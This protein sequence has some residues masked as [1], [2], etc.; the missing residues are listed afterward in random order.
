MRSEHQVDVLIVGA[1]P[2]GGQLGRR[3]QALG[4]SVLLVDRLA[5]FEANA[6]S[7][8]GTVN[9]CMERFQLPDSVVG[10]K[11]RAL[12]IVTTRER[13]RWEEDEPVGTVLDFG[14]LRA[15]LAGEIEG[16][17]GAVW[18]GTEYLRREAIEGGE[19]VWLRRKGQE[20]A[21][22]AKVVV[23]ATGPARALMRGLAPAHAEYMRGTG[24]ELLVEV[25][26]EQYA[27]FKDTLVFYMGYKWM[28]RGYAWIFPMEA[29]TLKVGAGRISIG[30]ALT[31]PGSSLR[32]HVDL[33]LR[34][35][36]GIEEPKVLD[37]HGAVLKYALG[38]EDRFEDGAVIAIGDAVSTLNILGGEGIRHAMVGAEIALPFITAR[39]QDPARTFAGYREAVHA[40][41][42]A[43]WQASERH[44]RRKYLADSDERIDWQVRFLRTKR[45][46][47]ILDSLFNY[48]FRRVAL[49]SAPSYLAFKAK[50]AMRRMLGRA[51]SGA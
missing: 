32:S 45:L 22:E 47:F 42:K 23:D 5:S 43:T 17:G 10:A 34:E 7:S 30:E 35:E 25:P 49:A 3:L 2:A 18:M 24:L 4:H 33:V 26:P 13:G 20:I 36:L 31:P 48:N 11:W 50:R 16:A 9:E 15:F 28:P 39:L 41:F 19:R 27:R 44:S 29:N 46:E 8:A 38:M 6:F 40:K 37:T 14:R 12:E 21:V 1:G 51:R